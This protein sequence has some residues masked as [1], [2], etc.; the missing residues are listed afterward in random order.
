MKTLSKPEAELPGWWTRVNGRLVAHS[1]L[2]Q[3][4]A[5]S[6]TVPVLS[7][8]V[9]RALPVWRT[10]APSNTRQPKSEHGRMCESRSKAGARCFAARCGASRLPGRVNAPTDF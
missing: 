10:R 6:A 3:A 9:D 8:V 4:A 2:E 7:I 5:Y 1:P